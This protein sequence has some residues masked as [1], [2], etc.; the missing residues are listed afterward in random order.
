MLPSKTTKHVR[1]QDQIT[2]NQEKTKTKTK[3]QEQINRLFKYWSY[4]ND[5]LK[6]IITMFK[7]I[8]DEMENFTIKHESILN[9]ILQLKITGEFNNRYQHLEC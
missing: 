8:H 3:Q 2:K 6:N 4:Q 7:E 5:F 9:E 1:R